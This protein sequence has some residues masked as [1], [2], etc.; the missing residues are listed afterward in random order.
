M[1][2]VGEGLASHLKGIV[3]AHA[4]VHQQPDQLGNGHG[5]VGVVE[6]D[7]VELA[8]P[9]VVG[10]VG[11]LEGPQHILQGGGGQHILLLDAQP[12]A[13]VGGVVGVQDTGDILGLVLLIQ[14]PEIVLIVEGVEVQLLLG[15]ALP[16]PEGADVVG[17]IADDGHIIGDSQHGMVGELHLHGVVVAAVGPGI[18]VFRPVV[19]LLHLTAVGIEALLEQAEAV[20]QAV[21]AEGQIGAG[22]GV[23]EAGGQTTQT[24]VAQSIVLDV[25]QNGQIHAML[26]E[27]LLHLVQNP[28]VE[29]VAVHQTADEVFSREVEGLP[30]VQALVLG[31]APV[32][33]NGHHHGSAQSLMELLR[34]GL[35]QGDIVGVFQLSFRPLQ[36]IFTIILHLHS[37][38]SLQFWGQAS[39]GCPAGHTAP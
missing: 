17:A 27:Q 6:L 19:G 12:L 26:R 34:G 16:Q 29:Q 15:L 23:Q 28:Q 22:G 25:L 3:K 14:S 37:P 9:G 21:A 4:L 33:G 8:E 35:L 24:A 32:V 11:Q 36:D 5:R 13:L 20:A 1:V 30:L 10:A 39:S 18:A 7:G 31:A 2:G 38:F